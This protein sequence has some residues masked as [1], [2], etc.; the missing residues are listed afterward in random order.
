MRKNILQ[1]VVIINRRLFYTVVHSIHRNSVA[2]K[3]K[4]QYA[5]NFIHRCVMSA[6]VFKAEEHQ[7]AIMSSNFFII[8]N[9]F[10]V[11]FFR[12]V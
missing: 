10:W 7:K 2:E 9:M 8:R 11:F 1:N 3:C 6:M 4:E 12:F 5:K